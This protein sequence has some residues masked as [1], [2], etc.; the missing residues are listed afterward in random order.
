M[1]KNFFIYNYQY[2]WKK[3]KKDEWL[4]WYLTVGSIALGF[5]FN[6]STILFYY[7]MEFEPTLRFENPMYILWL[8]PFIIIF[9][10]LYFL[11]PLKLSV[12]EKRNEE[13]DKKWKIIYW[14]YYILTGIIYA[15]ALSKFSYF[16]NP[17][18]F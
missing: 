5:T 6:I 2:F 4:S 8:G 1:I 18:P 16:L 11:K 17:I 15:F 9:A 7:I 14:V 3:Q 12:E 13:I 10:L